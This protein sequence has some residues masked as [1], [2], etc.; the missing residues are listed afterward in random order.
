MSRFDRRLKGANTK[1][2]GSGA[3]CVPQPIPKRAPLLAGMMFSGRTI[4]TSRVTQNLRS[5]SNSSTEQTLDSLVNQVGS[6]ITTNNTEKMSSNNIEML[7]R[8][9]S[10]LENRNNVTAKANKAYD[11]LNK[12]LTALEKM[13]SE[14]MENMEKYVRNQEDRINLLTE[15]YRKTFR[16]TKHNNS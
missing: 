12:R 13:Y 8:R 10:R 15:D 16:N 14:N 5:T 6:N 11:N 1:K 2:P 4:G 9:I 7:S 3:A